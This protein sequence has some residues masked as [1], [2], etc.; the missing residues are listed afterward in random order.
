MAP[1][2]I[3]LLDETRAQLMRRQ[4]VNFPEK[5]IIGLIAGI[6]TFLVIFFA[7]L[8]IWLYFYFKPTKGCGH[9]AE[10]F[11]DSATL[12]GV[13]LASRFS[14]DSIMKEKEKPVDFMTYHETM[15]PSRMASDETVM[16]LDHAPATPEPT[17][18]SPHHFR[19]YSMRE[20]VAV[21]LEPVTGMVRKHE[22]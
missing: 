8:G 5:T 14:S 22:G 12:S 1:I 6:A 16:T 20:A 10:P 13:T 19:R 9:A 18:E 4:S 21:R 15:L 3:D 7:A 2:P 11:D 17:V